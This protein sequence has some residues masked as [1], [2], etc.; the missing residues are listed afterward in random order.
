VLQV[1]RSQPAN[2]A[3]RADV[4]VAELAAG[5]NAV[6]STRQLTA[7]GVDLL[8]Q[9]RIERPEV[10]PELLL[11]GRRLRQVVNHPRQTLARIR[12]ALGL[13]PS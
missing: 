1:S 6:V 11:D 2:I 7:C 10:N 9:A 4:A 3:T 5:Q 12:A 13:D 8:V